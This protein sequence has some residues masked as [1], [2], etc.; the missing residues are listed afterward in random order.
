MEMPLTTRVT[1][2]RPFAGYRFV[3][4]DACSAAR[5]YAMAPGWILYLAVS[6][7]VIICLWTPAALRD[8]VSRL[9]GERDFRLIRSFPF[10]AILALIFRR[11]LAMGRNMRNIKGTFPRH[12]IYVAASL[13]ILAVRLCAG[14]VVE[15]ASQIAQPFSYVACMLICGYAMWACYP[16]P[17]ARVVVRSNGSLDLKA[18]RT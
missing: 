9:S 16:G 10:L 7:L 4:A 11:G 14:P 8:S 13:V 6:C 17:M 1:L 15:H 5:K 12:G 3:R 18:V 2:G